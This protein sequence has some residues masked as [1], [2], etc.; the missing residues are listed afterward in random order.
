MNISV[1]LFAGARE[2]AGANQLTLTAPRPITVSALRTLLVMQHP[3]L[4]TLANSLLVAVDADYAADD[5][6]LTEA[7]EVAVF[8]PVSGG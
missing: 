7:N 8:P 6:V 3:A 1:R 2:L 5:R 4:R